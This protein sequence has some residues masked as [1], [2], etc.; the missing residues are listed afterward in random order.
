MLFHEIYSCYYNAVAEILSLAVEKALTPGKM[1][2]IIAEK[3]CSESFLEII[4]ALT[5]EKWQLLD[6]NLQTPLKHIPS[7]PV[8]TLQKRWLKAISLDKRI[9]LFGV[10]FDLPD[11]IQPL[12]TPDDF[13]VFDKYA[14]GDPYEDEKYIKIFRTVLEAV[15]AQQKIKVEYA[16]H[17]GNC[18]RITC[19]P[20]K[21]E[22]SEKDDKFRVF[23]SGCRFATIMNIANIK[24]C[25]IIG[26]ARS[27]R[28]PEAIHSSEYFIAE[29][30]DERNA[31]ER[32][33]L[34]FAHFKKQAERLPGSR[35]RIQIFY[36]KNDELE[37]LIRVL[38]FGPFVKVTEPDTFIELIKE[39]LKKQ[40]NCGLK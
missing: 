14:D 20:Y 1:K 12:F 7:M 10:K 13:V 23:V 3:A 17:K 39:R 31:L 15:H 38:S 9:K 8:T 6:A 34:H 19:D 30:V 18:R 4:P 37:L 26:D 16:G 35:Y 27:P 11:D 40:K 21:I 33:M 36:D 24:E 32:F 28:L 25:E 29:L 5:T 2:E 22:Y